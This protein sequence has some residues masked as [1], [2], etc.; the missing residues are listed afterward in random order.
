MTK[1]TTVLVDCDGTLASSQILYFRSGDVARSFST[2]DGEG[3]A[4]LKQHGIRVA[5]VT[6]SDSAEIYN[7]AKW[8]GIGCYGSVYDKA[9]FLEFF[10][11]D[12]LK[13][14]IKIELDEICFMGNDL[15]DLDAETR[16]MRDYT[17]PSLYEGTYQI[18]DMIIKVVSIILIAMILFIPAAPKIIDTA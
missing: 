11:K 1:I 16:A 7:R 18:H 8:L 4:R 9:E 10:I 13:L 6:Q 17:H 15:N 5:I 3:V 2:Y 14:G 12:E